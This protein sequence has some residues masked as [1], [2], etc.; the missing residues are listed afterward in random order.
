MRFS[1]RPR[2]GERIRLARMSLEPVAMRQGDLATRLGVSQAR[3]SNWE[4][5]A[6]VPSVELLR[7]IATLLG[8]SI[9][10]LLGDDVPMLPGGGEV[11]VYRSGYRFIPVKGAI[12][13]GA[14]C[15]TDADLD[16][17]E[18]RDWGGATERW[19]RVIQGHSMTSD[20]FGADSL[21]SGDVAVFED[22]RPELGHVVHAFDNGDDTVKVLRQRNGGPVELC[23]LNPSYEPIDAAGWRVKGVL[24]MRIRR[25]E[26]GIVET[27]EYPHG[28]RPR[29][30]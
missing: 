23:P 12:A 21:L 16:W 1:D 30:A 18:I 7:R 14:P 25:R 24:V 5:G 26:H 8:V 13:A 10:W 3:L 6:H 19:G 20:R 28:M 27:V 11:I 29:G 2:I 22:R 15:S 9:D 17:I 4:R